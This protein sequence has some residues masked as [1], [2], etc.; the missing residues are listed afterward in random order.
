M[1]KYILQ[2]ISCGED[3][4][5]IVVLVRKWIFRWVTLSKYVWTSW[6]S[7]SLCSSD[8]VCEKTHHHLATIVK[9]REIHTERTNQF[10]LSSTQHNIVLFFKFL[11]SAATIKTETIGCV[12]LVYN[13]VAALRTNDETDDDDCYILGFAQKIWWANCITRNIWKCV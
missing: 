12:A 13:Y 1:I 4:D 10:H 2:L 7:N 6:T 9:N 8:P 5:S 3:S 11:N